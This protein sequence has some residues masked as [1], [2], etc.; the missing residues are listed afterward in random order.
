[1]NQ[2]Y[3]VEIA[4]ILGIATILGF[5]GQKLKQ[6]LVIM[7]LL[8]GILTGPAFLGIIQSYEQIEL[9][10]NIGIAVLLFIVG[11]KLDLSLI[12]T[13]GPVALATGLGQIIF[14]S[15]IGFIISI[16]L[17]IN[18]IN[19]AYIA[20][21][22]TFSS[23]IIIVKLLSDKK[24][25]DSLH[26]QIAIGFLIVQDIGAIV[27]LIF[28]TT[29]GSTVVSETSSFMPFLFIFLKAIAFIA[30]IIIFMKLFIF[31]IIH[32]VANSQELLVLFAISWAIILGAS[33]EVL[34]FSKEVGAFFAGVSL[35]STKYRDSIGSRLT[36]LRDFL[37]LF[38]FI[39][40]GSRL[41]LSIVGDQLLKASILSFF[42]LIGNPLIVLAI[43]G[44]MGYRKRTSFLAGLTVAQISEF[45]LILAALG[46][47]M[48]HIY[49]QT[50]GL[51]TLIGIITILVSTYMILYSDIIYTFLSKFLNLFERK[52]PYRECC[53]NT[54]KKKPDTDIILM[55]LGNYGGVIANNLLQKNKTIIGVDFDP[56]CLEK[57][58]KKGVEVLY[59]DIVDPE[60]HE[61][62]PLSKA[63]WVVSTVRSKQLN[64]TLLNN[65]KS[66][67]YKGQIALT[68]RGKADAVIYEKNG[69]SMVFRPFVDA[70]EQAVDFLSH[71]MELLPKKTNWPINFLEFKINSNSKIAGSKIKDIPLRFE[72]GVSILAVSRSGSVYYNPEP[73]YQIY[74]SDRLILVG[75]T[76]SLIQSEKLFKRFQEEINKKQNFKKEF[77]LE[78]FTVS[79]NSEFLNIS[80]NDSNFRQKY[81]ANVIGIKRNSSNIINPSPNEK[82]LN[83]D[84]LLILG[85]IKTINKL[86]NN[87]NFI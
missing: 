19:S 52:N 13:T 26:G 75:S 27:A 44:F 81:N 40:L 60:I 3:F 68:A 84:K 72:T 86:K 56:I 85:S 5:I 54:I 2:N 9:L 50:M 30:A 14:T 18:I 82:I 7:F 20:V 39:D 46:L 78:E 76:D 42:V 77:V 73:D 6:P 59:A 63:K 23:T 58:A 4:S 33:S 62:L 12:K 49:K 24:E 8:A 25:I 38:F 57:W 87:K 61:H 21:A 10:A 11:L 65:L 67:N 32:K 16:S 47:S 28:L 22:L 1:M 37:L 64:I 55:G 71:A 66:L 53:F 51:I 34:G 29:L 74:P 48:G 83:N 41:D 43:M 69:A 36:S 80:L 45:S 79:N 15:L 31:K 70:A 35:A 17:G